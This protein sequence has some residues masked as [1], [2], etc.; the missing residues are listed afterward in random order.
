MAVRESEP[1]L[2]RIEVDT[3]TRNMTYTPS[4]LHATPGDRVSWFCTGGNFT[5]AFAER[6]PFDKVQIRG[7]RRAHSRGE[8][9]FSAEER[10]KEGVRGVYPYAVAVAID[11]EVFL[12]ASCPIIIIE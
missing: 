4:V 10:I 7:S 5:L 2:V 1:K 8:H 3:K 9:A 11:G 12:D 6:T